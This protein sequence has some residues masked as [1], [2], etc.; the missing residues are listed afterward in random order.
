M[1]NR[2]QMSRAR[3]GTIGAEPIPAGHFAER[4]RVHLPAAERE[5]QIVEA[6]AAFF[7]EHGFS[8]QTRELAKT[9]GIT[10][11]AIFRYFP[12]KESLIERMY[13]HVFL[14]RWNPAWRDLIQD[15]SQTLEQRLLLFYRTYVDRIFDDTWV[16]IFMH[17]GLGG[18]PI[19]SRYMALVGDQLIVPMCGELRDTLALPPPEAAPLTEREQEAAW[20]LHGKVFYLAIRRFI[21]RVTIPTDIQPII[22]DDVRTFLAGAPALARE[23]CA[24]A[25]K[26]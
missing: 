2:L 7:A 10:H 22:E 19:A 11:S 18:Y 4:R 13:E 20:G 15:R 26:R 23:A 5:L 24:A 25:A 9:M 1:T 12:T 3:R 6:A 16:R 8:G 21:Y 17:S 14:N